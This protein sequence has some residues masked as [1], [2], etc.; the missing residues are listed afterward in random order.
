MTMA[1]VS[2]PIDMEA[3]ENAVHG[4]FSEVTGLE[5]IWRNQSAPQPEYPYASLL[6]INGPDPL[7]PQWEQRYDTDL[8]RPAGQEMRV[9]VCV[10][11]RFTVSCQVYV[12]TPD[13]RNP[14]VNA[15]LFMTK[16]QSSLSLP[17]VL[18]VL[19]A[20]GIAVE[21]SGSVQNISAIIEDA[22]ASRANMDVVFGASLSLEELTGYLAKIQAESVSLGI[23]QEFGDI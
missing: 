16:A 4:W 21:R 20:A 12:G 17:S 3:F 1:V 14:Q 2:D 13:A 7:A 6:V 22:F 15:L 8:G 11:C 10:P 9:T 23:D 18:A 5:T 19:W